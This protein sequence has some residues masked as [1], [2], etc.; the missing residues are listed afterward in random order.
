MNLLVSVNF[1]IVVAI[2][3]QGLW[4]GYYGFGSTT[5]ELTL[6]CW[7]NVCIMDFLL[8]RKAL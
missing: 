5:V 6:W 7:A 1:L 4:H 8:R 3:L 2:F